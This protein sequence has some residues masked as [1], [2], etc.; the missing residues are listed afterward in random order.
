V[1]NILDDLDIEP[2]ETIL[3][4]ISYPSQDQRT[5]AFGNPY[6][7]YFPGLELLGIDGILNWVQTDPSYIPGEGAFASVILKDN[8]GM[9]IPQTLSIYRRSDGDLDVSISAN[10][11]SRIVLESSSDFKAWTPIYTN[12]LLNTYSTIVRVPGSGQKGFFRTRI[13]E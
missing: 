8:D 3:M 5:D 2:N 12:I 4:D 7:I 10:P 6:T 11:E 1:M 9:D 13:G